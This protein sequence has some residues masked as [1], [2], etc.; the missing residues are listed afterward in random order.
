M[1]KINNFDKVK[2]SVNLTSRVSSFHK[3]SLD[4]YSIGKNYSKVSFT[5]SRF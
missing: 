2:D 4:K 5:V 3:S 1:P